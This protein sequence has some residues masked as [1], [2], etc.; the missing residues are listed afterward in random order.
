MS[1]YDSDTKNYYDIKIHAKWEGNH[2]TPSQSSS[3]VSLDATSCHSFA[4]FFDSMFNESQCYW[5]SAVG[6]LGGGGRHG[7]L[8]SSRHVRD[9]PEKTAAPVCH[10]YRQRFL[11]TLKLLQSH[12]TWST[13]CY[14]YY[15]AGWWSGNSLD[16]Y[17]EVFG[18][19]LG[20]DTG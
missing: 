8:A 19:D 3:S 11:Q 16:F 5:L 20:W 1:N 4:A 18:F 14:N 13:K 17:A 2:L 15:W 9:K 10:H 6:R 7:W 12:V